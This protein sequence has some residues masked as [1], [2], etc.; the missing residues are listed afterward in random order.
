V[1]AR[2]LQRLSTPLLRFEKEI[3]VFANI[4]T[5]IS[6]IAAVVAVIG[7]TMQIDDARKAVEAQTVY[8]MQKDARELIENVRKNPAVFEY[9]FKHEDGKTYAPEVVKDAEF[10]ILKLIQFYSAIF[11]QHRNGVI[12]ETYWNLGDVL[13]IVHRGNAKLCP[14]QTRSRLLEID[15]RRQQL[16]RGISEIR[17]CIADQLTPMKTNCLALLLCLASTSVRADL[18]YQVRESKESPA[19]A[20]AGA[21]VF[22]G[23]AD[24]YE[25]FAAIERSDGSKAGASAS[26]A[27]KKF[28]AAINAYDTIRAKGAG[29][30]LPGPG[31]QKENLAKILASLRKYDIAL[32]KNEGEAAALAV[33]EIKRFKERFGGIFSRVM[34]KDV[35]A[36]R[37]LFD[38]IARLQDIGSNVALLNGVPRRPDRK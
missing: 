17:H 2:I 16:Q 14:P 23:V 29:L 13:E 36:L 5:A 38:A 26:S 20:E 9:I 31:F 37:E 35:D 10:E 19:W 32:P 21:G 28:D 3:T 1:F 30:S 4:A 6:G 24:L 11:N 15:D 12:S 34:N 33:N 22:E 25:A 18:I 27:M 7:L 8:S